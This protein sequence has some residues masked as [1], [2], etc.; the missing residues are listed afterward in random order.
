MVV[1]YVVVLFVVVF[2]IYCKTYLLEYF[3]VSFSPY[4]YLYFFS[5][6]NYYKYAWQDLIAKGYDLKPDAIPIV[7]AKAARHAASDVSLNHR[8]AKSSLNDN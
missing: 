5:F 6:Q 2:L 1:N 7:A 3:S 4:V 8:I